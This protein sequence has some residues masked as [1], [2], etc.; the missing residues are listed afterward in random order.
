MNLD[1]LVQK[2]QYQITLRYSCCNYIGILVSVP[3]IKGKGLLSGFIIL[4]W[5]STTTHWE[6]H[7]GGRNTNF[8]IDRGLSAP[9][10]SYM[11]CC[12]LNNGSTLIFSGNWKTLSC[13]ACTMQSLSLSLCPPT[14]YPQPEATSSHSREVKDKEL[15]AITC[16]WGKAAQLLINVPS[17]WI[18]GFL[19]K[20]VQNF[21]AV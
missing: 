11:A 13:L 4:D 16:I 3:V 12:V 7:R 8:S 1:D 17:G 9:E 15:Q 10:C 2:R 6:I 5:C 20:T 21:S 14:H 18:N 19:S